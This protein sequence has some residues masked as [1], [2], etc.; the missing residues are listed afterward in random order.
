MSEASEKHILT[1]LRNVLVVAKE[2]YSV[3]S[4]R[5]DTVR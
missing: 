2:D 3:V 4:L 5:D 1:Y